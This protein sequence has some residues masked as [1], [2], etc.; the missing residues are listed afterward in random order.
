MDM[1][2]ILQSDA[3]Q[4]L[5]SKCIQPDLNLCNTSPNKNFPNEAGDVQQDLSV[6]NSECNHLEVADS[7]DGLMKAEPALSA[8]D[9]S[10]TSSC[11]RT[12]RQPKIQLIQELST[13]IGLARQLQLLDLSNNGFTRDLAEALYTAW[14]STFRSG[15]SARRHVEEH[16]VHFSVDDKKCCGVKICCKK[17]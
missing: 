10:A 9:D 16:T 13:A 7:E 8:L 2:D 6:V 1:E 12:T 3:A 5:S 4:E 17:D 14:S 11:R 15:G